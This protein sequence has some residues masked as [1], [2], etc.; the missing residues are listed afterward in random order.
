MANKRVQATFYPRAPDP[1]RSVRAKK[2]EPGGPFFPES[3]ADAAHLTVEQIQI[4]GPIEVVAG[5]GMGGGDM[6]LEH[7]KRR[8]PGVPR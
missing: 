4:G 5:L 8:T 1:Q 6:I 7:G 3:E 2:S